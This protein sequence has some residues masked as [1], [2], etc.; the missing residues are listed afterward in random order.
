ICVICKNEFSKKTSMGTLCKHL[1]TQH[2]GWSTIELFW[3]V[4]D[5]LPFSTVESKALIALLHFLNTTLELPS[6]ETI[7]SIVQNSFISMRS[8]VQALFGQI[9]SNISITLDIWTSRANMPFLGITAHWINSNWNLKKILVDMCML[10]HPHTGENI[11]TKLESILATF[12]ITTKIICATTDSGSNVI[13][14]IRL[15]N[16]HLSMQNFYFYSRHC[17]AHVLHLIVMA[18]MTPIKTSIEK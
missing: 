18:G 17:L 12:N 14:A 4:S 13:S 2:P 3:I 9:F 15:L 11:E 8:D 10:L 5:T 16:M 1:D 7:K 6:R